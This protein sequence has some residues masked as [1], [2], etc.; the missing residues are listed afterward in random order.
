MRLGRRVALERRRHRDLA[1]G[2]AGAGRARGRAP[3]R[4]G[5]HRHRGPHRHSPT[6]WPGPGGVDP[7][8]R[9]RHVHLPRLRDHRGRGPAA[10]RGRAPAGRPPGGAEHL[11]G[12]GRGRC[13]GRRGGRA[14][15]GARERPRRQRPRGLHNALVYLRISL[16][17]LPAM[18][19]VLAGWA[20][21][22]AFRTPRG[23]SRWRWA[24]RWGTSCSEAVLIFG[25]DQGIGAS[26]LSTSWPRPRP[27]LCSSGGSDRQSDATTW[28][29][30]PDLAII[31]RLA[32]AGW[33]LLIRPR[34]C[35][36]A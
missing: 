9:P 27:R 3:L 17:G 18:L 30:G 33:D 24:P 2:L 26:A 13:A 29:C 12:A 23:P 36:S 15:A 20:T 19:V 11:A 14:G 1:A 22:E 8:D 34:R 35:G 5:R 7:A 4:A 25:F 10:G 21:C 31:R 32:V 16:F 6:R 28:A